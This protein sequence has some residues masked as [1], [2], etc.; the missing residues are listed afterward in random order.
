MLGDSG[1]SDFQ[2]AGKG[3]SARVRAFLFVPHKKRSTPR[4]SGYD[5]TLRVK[6]LAFLLAES[7]FRPIFGHTP[8][9]LP[10]GTS[11]SL[12]QPPASTHIKLYNYTIFLHFFQGVLKNF[13]Y[14]IART[15]AVDFVHTAQKSHSN[16]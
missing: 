2:K 3:G 8:Q 12:E 7:F 4:L 9:K 11:E 13:F 15:F 16:T 5:R 1:L 14:E 10:L 6:G